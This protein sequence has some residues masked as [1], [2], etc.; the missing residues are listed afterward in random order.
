M[1]K[2]LLILLLLTTF[3][4]GGSDEIESELLFTSESFV[5]D[6]ESA[7]GVTNSYSFLVAKHQI[8]ADHCLLFYYGTKVGFVKGDYTAENGYGPQID[9]FATIIN[10]NLGLDYDLKASQKLSFEG[11]RSQDE[12]TG[13]VE[14]Y[15]KVGYRYRF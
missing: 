3:L 15:V 13:H 12:Y 8:R 2:I 6:H 5:H 7:Y 11:S 9:S 10:T 4:H 1:K 14:S